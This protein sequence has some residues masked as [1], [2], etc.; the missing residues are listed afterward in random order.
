MVLSRNPRGY[1]I[2]TGAIVFNSEEK[3]GDAPLLW[4]LAWGTPGQGSGFVQHQEKGERFS[5]R[6]HVAR[7][8]ANV[9]NTRKTRA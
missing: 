6:F 3:T 5:S 8:L 9:G 1:G 4:E 7:I 2:Y